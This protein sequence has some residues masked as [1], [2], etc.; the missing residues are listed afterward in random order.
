MNLGATFKTMIHTWTGANA[1][2]LFVFIEIAGIYLFYLIVLG[3]RHSN[4][5]FDHEPCQLFYLNEVDLFL[6]GL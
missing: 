1:K 6:D 5:I 2:G 3:H 4:A